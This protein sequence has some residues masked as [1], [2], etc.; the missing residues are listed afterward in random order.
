M[1]KTLLIEFDVS[2]G[3]L[4]KL[5]KTSSPTVPRVGH[6]DG[7]H[8]DDNA[9][10][11]SIEEVSAVYLV[12]P[13]RLTTTVI[14]FSGTLGSTTRNDLR[15]L[16]M[17][18]YAHYVAQETACRYIFAD[19]QGSESPFVRIQILT[20]CPATLGSNNRNASGKLSLTLFDP[21]SHTFEGYVVDKYTIYPLA[22]YNCIQDIRHRRSRR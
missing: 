12:E 4:I 20:S 14:K 8:D 17:N 16:T 10:V 5:Y 22:T 18:A 2:D 6:A 19:I 1:S 7:N 15:S 11:E 9:P 3:F 21:M 13:L